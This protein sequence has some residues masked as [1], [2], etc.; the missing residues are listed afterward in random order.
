MVNN[1][2]SRAIRLF[3]SS[4]FRDFGEERDLLVKRVFPAL[5]ARLKDRF[6]ELV[7]TATVL[8]NL[9]ELFNVLKNPQEAELWLER[10]LEIRKKF[11]SPDHPLTAA[12]LDNLAKA[13]AAQG[14]KIAAVK[15]HERALTSR[16]NALD[17]QHPDTNNSR[18]NLGTLWFN[19][20]NYEPAHGNWL[21]SM[22]RM[23][24]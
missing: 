20:Q 19:E 9:G 11:L 4:T 1:Q 21:F 24:M 7:E 3:L 16:I 14:R 18:V 2:P 23:G 10:C 6:V 17:D 8:N 22:L 15:N 12:T 5:R 13:Q